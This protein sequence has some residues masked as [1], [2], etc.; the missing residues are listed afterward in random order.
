MSAIH[1]ILRPLTKLARRHRRQLLPALGTSCFLLAA[2]AVLAQDRGALQQE[3]PSDPQ[4]PQQPQFEIRLQNFDP[5]DIRIRIWDLELGTPVTELPPQYLDPHCGTNGGPPSLRL[6]HWSEFA[7]CPLDRTTGLHEIWFTEDD[8]AEYIARSYRQQT[9]DPGPV[10]A[11]V[12]F[13]HKVIYSLLV[14]DAGLVQGYRIFTD[15]RESAGVRQG[16]YN[17]GVPLRNLYG[18]D[19]FDCVSEPPGERQLDVDGLYANERCE[20][21]VGDAR[22]TIERHLFRKP[23]QTEYDPIGRI[24]VGAFE[25]TSRIEVIRASLTRE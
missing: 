7:K 22:V 20:G 8:E 2:A 15:N 24:N 6:D 5:G 12:L 9:F 17:V 18:Y 16:A 25:S 13:N 19:A 21:V 10:S 1:P 4:V 11:D 23:G 3:A 14:D